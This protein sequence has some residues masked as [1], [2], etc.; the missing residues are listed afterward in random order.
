MYRQ[1][2][3]K[4]YDWGK[5]LT[6]VIWTYPLKNQNTSTWTITYCILVEINSENNRDFKTSHYTF[7]LWSFASFASLRQL[8]W[9]ML[10]VDSA[11]HIWTEAVSRSNNGRSKKSRD[12]LEGPVLLLLTGS[13]VNSWIYEKRRPCLVRF[14]R[15]QMSK[16]LHVEIAISLSRNGLLQSCARFFKWSKVNRWMVNTWNG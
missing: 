13:N 9:P 12:I 3:Q 10:L 15:K 6:I 16:M 14:V 5:N 11:V 2:W 7:F 8:A 4:K 1:F